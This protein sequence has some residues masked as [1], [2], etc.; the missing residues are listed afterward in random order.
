MAGIFRHEVIVGT[1]ADWKANQGPTRDAKSAG[2]PATTVSWAGAQ[3]RGERE[4][5]EWLATFSTKHD[6]ELR[7]IRAAEAKVR[8]ER[9]LLQFC[10]AFSTEHED[11]LR[12]VL[13]EEA[14]ARQAQRQPPRNPGDWPVREAWDPAKHPRSGAPPNPGWWASAGGTTG[15]GTAGNSAAALPSATVQPHTGLSRRQVDALPPREREKLAANIGARGHD[16]KERIAALET[17]SGYTAANV[18]WLQRN[19]SRKRALGQDTAA[20]EE[21]VKGVTG[22]LATTQSEI[23]RLKEADDRLRDEFHALGLGNVTFHL[24]DNATPFGGYDQLSG[25]EFQ[26]RLRHG[27]R[28]GLAGDFNI[29]LAAGTFGA[30]FLPG[31]AAGGASA[32]ARGAA[33]RGNIPPGNAELGAAISSAAR[34]GL[35]AADKVRQLK[36]SASRIAGVTFKEVNVPG[37]EGAFVGQTARRGHTPFLVVMKDGRMY[38]GFVEKA[39]VPDP[40][41]R[42]NELRLMVTR[43]TE[44][45]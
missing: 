45:E 19:I 43:P 14:E 40:S 6:R 30:S 32:I 1:G 17:Q 11:E 8:R 16:L 25:K 3:V 4:R 7:D 44:V 23:D 21:L 9:E 20:D 38:K 12:R 15:G 36:V 29:P 33:V 5:V 42:T 31:V 41:G 37:V 28:D 27:T 24:T 22:R 2:T 39:L 35:S 18:D 26:G 13:R 10:A 34:S